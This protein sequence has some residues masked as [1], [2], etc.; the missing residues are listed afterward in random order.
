MEY[1]VSLA[2]NT[3]NTL[4]LVV[5]KDQELSSYPKVNLKKLSSVTDD[6]NVIKM[7]KSCLLE[8][9]S[10]PNHIATRVKTVR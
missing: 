2:I 7:I 8:L 1:C 5:S 9:I 10:Y 4:T 3:D 6:K